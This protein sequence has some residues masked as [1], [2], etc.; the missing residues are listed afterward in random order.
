MAP[1][2]WRFPD[3]LADYY[4]RTGKLNKA[5]ELSLQAVSLTPDNPRALNN[6]GRVYYRLGRLAEARTAYENANLIEPG[7]SRYANLGV[8]LDDEG[9]PLEAASAY[10]KALELNAGSSVVWGNLGSALASAGREAEARKAYSRAIALAEDL[11]AKRPNDAELV[12]QLGR[13]YASLGSAEKSIPLLR[14]AVTLTPDDPQILFRQAIA[15]E[16]LHRRSDALTCVDL[17]LSHGLIFARVEREPLMASLR[18]DPRFLK[19]A[20]QHKKKP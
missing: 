16:L 7:Y 12:S 1:S 4:L 20:V 15:Y 8:I 3:N 5:L 6:L 9:K 10:R 18:Q 2:D 17:A 11:R 19:L 14:Q 13:Y